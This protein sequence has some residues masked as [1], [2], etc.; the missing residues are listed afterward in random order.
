M[1]VTWAAGSFD[2]G[3]S[4]ST[5]RTNINNFNDEVSAS[6]ASSDGAI[7]S[8][9]AKADANAAAIVAKGLLISSNT[10]D[11]AENAALIASNAPFIPTYDYLAP[12]SYVVTA[13]ALGTTVASL[14]TVS[15]PAGTYKLSLSTIYT[16]GATSTD[17]NFRFSVD[18]VFSPTIS[19]EPKDTTNSNPLANFS[20]IVHTGG[21]ITIVVE[22]WK[23]GTAV[24]TL[25]SLNIAVERV[26]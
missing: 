12:A 1:A 7:T 22:A 26:I 10:T 16:Y 13:T 18:G 17:V 8:V 24:F 9:N 19:V 23:T 6:I 21:I 15:R 11:I 14:T 25:E 5:V 2:N 20:T 4:L 3:A